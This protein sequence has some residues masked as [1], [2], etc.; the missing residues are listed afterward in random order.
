MIYLQQ[1]VQTLRAEGIEVRDQDSARHS[2]TCYEHINCLNKYSFPSQVDVKHNGLRKPLETAWSNFTPRCHKKAR[3]A[4]ATC[5]CEPS[6]LFFI[7]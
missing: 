4:L 5:L 7:R 2:P 1:V 6:Y 3:M